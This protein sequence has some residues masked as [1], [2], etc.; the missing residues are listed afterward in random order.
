M[1]RII[2]SVFYCL[3]LVLANGC[4]NDKPSALDDNTI[5]EGVDGMI[6]LALVQMNVVGGDLDLN[7]RHAAQRI[8]EAAGGGA[9]LALLPEMMDLG[10]THPSG[11]TMAY[12][13]PGGKTFVQLSKAARR[14]TCQED[15]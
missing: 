6:K 2:Y 13:V 12:P 3:A 5:K 14:I 15:P 11:K 10:W 8:A 7:L 1:N 4:G 9:Q